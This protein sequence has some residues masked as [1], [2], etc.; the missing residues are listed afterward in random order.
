MPP[1][2]CVAEFISWVKLCSVIT[3]CNKGNI[4]LEINKSETR[5]AC[6]G[7]ICLRIGTKL[8]ICIEGFPQMRSTKFRVIC[9]SVLRGDVFRNQSIRNKNCQWQPC[10]LMDRDKM[11]NHYRGHSKDPSHQIA[12][13]RH[14]CKQIGKK[15][16]IFVEGFPLM[17]T[18]K[19][20]FI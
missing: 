14:V 3:S 17:L 9:P 12:C 10:L 19:F 5:I 16:A 4:C 18:T 15:L 13:G 2:L 1:S 20:L 7:H 11:C 8:A 6:G